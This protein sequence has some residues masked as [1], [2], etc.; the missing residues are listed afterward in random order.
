[1]MKIDKNKCV[2]CGACVSICPNGFEMIN[3][4]AKIKDENAKCINEAVLVCPQQAIIN[5]GLMNQ[6]IKLNRR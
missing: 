4:K 1:M 2:G 3:G 6:K 5:D